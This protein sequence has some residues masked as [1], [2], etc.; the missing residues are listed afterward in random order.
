MGV[1]ILVLVMVFS[2][3]RVWNCVRIPAKLS[4]GA[5]S[6]HAGLR[7]GAHFYIF[8]GEAHGHATNE[9]WRLH[10]GK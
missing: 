9:L 3:S 1:L 6:G 7:A 4:P 10:F 5:R 8:G 2:V